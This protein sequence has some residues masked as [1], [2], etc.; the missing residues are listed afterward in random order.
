MSDDIKAPGLI[1]DPR[2]EAEKVKDF[3]HEEV[4][5]AVALNWNK[6]LQDA[7]NHSQRDQNGS[8]SC[9]AQAT[10]KAEEVLKK[11]VPSAHPIYA[12]RSNFPNPGM[13]LQN[14]GEIMR[15]QGT[16]TEALDPSQKMSEVQMNAPVTVDTPKK[17]P[18]YI[19]ITDFKNIDKIAE[20]IELY[21]HCVITVGCNGSEWTEKPVYSGNS[22][23]NFF[24]AV[25]ATYYFKDEQGKKCLR[26]DESWGANNPGH[27][28]IT[29][30]F[31]VARGTAA[32]Y[33]IPDDGKPHHTF[34]QNLHFGMMSNT[35]VKFLQ[36]ILKFEK[37]FPLSQL[38]TGNY[39]QITARAVLAFQTKYGIAPPS[40]NDVGPLTRAKLNEL[41]GN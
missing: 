4:S 20:A 34:R 36:D 1:P 25:C 12:R 16:T 30:D 7:P 33:F 6:P 35:E 37:L 13:W 11:Y 26:I 18:L 24:H 29:E 21:G 19:T 39:L 28:I 15:K 40:A 9:V 38:S 22:L 2:S 31:W 41:Y 27:R 5:M 8:G 17:E 23:L 32:M 10:A 14:A 3:K